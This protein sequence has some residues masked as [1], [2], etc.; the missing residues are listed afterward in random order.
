M[1]PLAIFDSRCGSSS[2]Q[3]SMSSWINL[4]MGHMKAAPSWT[5]HT[6]QTVV[7]GLGPQKDTD[8]IYAVFFRSA[9]Y[10][11]RVTCG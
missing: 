2:L 7:P 10:S 3:E 11:Y 6:T 4:V 8:A 1:Y 5:D 9:M